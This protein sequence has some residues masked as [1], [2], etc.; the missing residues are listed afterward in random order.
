[1]LKEN[2]E[3]TSHTGGTTM[4]IEKNKM[5]TGVE[6]PPKRIPV[7]VLDF[8]REKGGRNGKERIH[9]GADHQ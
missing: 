3:I 8:N 1:V 4:S 5:N 7:D 2:S 9:T 6:C